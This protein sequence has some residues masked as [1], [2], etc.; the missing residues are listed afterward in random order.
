VLLTLAPDETERTWCE[1][2]E[3][4]RWAWLA[5]T[6]QI[7]TNSWSIPTVTRLVHRWKA[8]LKPDAREGL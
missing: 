8:S 7:F 6:N 3:A 4:R 1:A 5:S 2:T